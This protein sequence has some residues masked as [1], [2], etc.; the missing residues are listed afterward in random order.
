MMKSAPSVSAADE[1]LGRFHRPA[2]SRIMRNASGGELRPET[3]NLLV[4]EA[5]TTI[6]FELRMR[7]S[8][9]ARDRAAR[10][11]GADE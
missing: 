4:R 10:P 2:G 5:C 11:S 6:S 7:A 8:S 1:F 9:M 3:G